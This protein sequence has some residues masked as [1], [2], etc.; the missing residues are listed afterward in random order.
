MTTLATSLSADAVGD[1]LFAYGPRIAFSDATTGTERPALSFISPH[2]YYRCQINV[3]LDSGSWSASDLMSIIVKT[4]D[5]PIYL[6]KWIISD[7]TLGNPQMI[8]PIFVVLAPDTVF[9]VLLAFS[10][11]I[12]MTGS[13]SAILTGTRRL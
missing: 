7:F 6:S 13:G 1:S 9:E 8:N 10:S 12:A 2:D 11:S 3:S 4:N 5:I